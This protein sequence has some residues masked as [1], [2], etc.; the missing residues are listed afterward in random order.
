[1]RTHVIPEL[2]KKSL[3]AGRRALIW[4]THHLACVPGIVATTALM[5]IERL[6]AG[7]AF[8]RTVQS[9]FLA[10]LVG[11]LGF[12]ERQWRL[13]A[14]RRG[15]VDL[16]VEVDGAERMLVIIE[17]KGTDWDKIPAA[18]LM[19]NLRRHLHQLQ[20][21]LDTAIEEMEAGD[22]TGIVGSLLYPARPASSETLATIEAVAGEQAVMVT[23]YED[24]D[25]HRPACYP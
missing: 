4:P 6:A 8:H 11:A 18:R 24:V 2:R 19:R 1:M 3:S 7:Q 12:P 10:G 17:I 22:W 20:G 15:R 9:A 16:A 14:G 25:W 23:W 21:Y 13:L 5:P